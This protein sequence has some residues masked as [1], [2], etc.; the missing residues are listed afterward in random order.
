VLIPSFKKLGFN[1]QGHRA[2]RQKNKEGEQSTTPEQKEKK[3]KKH[4]ENV[5][6]KKKLYSLI[7][8]FKLEIQRLRGSRRSQK[9]A[10]CFT[11]TSK[12]RK[13]LK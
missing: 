5:P 13:N 8:E 6:K 9:L 3:K 7:K 12:G 2:K 11:Q 1:A 4:R 10:A